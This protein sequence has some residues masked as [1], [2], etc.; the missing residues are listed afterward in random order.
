L[1]GLL[2]STTSHAA[3]AHPLSGKPDIIVIQACG[4][5]HRRQSILKAMHC[6]HS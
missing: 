6:T 4:P 1:H 3:A 5:T 2:T